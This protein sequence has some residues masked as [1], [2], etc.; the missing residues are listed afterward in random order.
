MPPRGKTRDQVAVWAGV[1]ARTVQDAATVQRHDPELFQRVKA[2]ELAAE[3][4]ARRVRRALR[5]QALQAP[6]LPEGP[7]ELIYADPPWQLGNPDGRHAPENHYPTMP[8]EQITALA[9]PA[10]EHAL[11]LLWAVNCLLP[12]ALQVVEAWG[13][14]YKTNL[15]WVKPSIGLG[16]C[17]QPARAAPAGDKGTLPAPAGLPRL[18]ARGATRPSL[19]EAGRRLRANR[20]GLAAR[21]QARTLRPHRP[22]RLDRLGKPS[23]RARLASAR[24]SSLARTGGWIFGRDRATSLT[25]AREAR[26]E[27]EEVEPLRANGK[28]LGAYMR[29]GP[30]RTP[31]PAPEALLEGFC[32]QLHRSGR[33]AGTEARY[34]RV[35]AGFLGQVEARAS[36]LSAGELDAYLSDW[37]A[38]FAARHGRAP[39]PASYRGQVNALR[40]FYHYLERLELLADAQGRPLLNP[41]RAIACPPAAQAEND[42]LR[43]DED[44]ALLTCPGSLQERFAVALLRHT[45]MRVSEAAAVTLAELDLAAGREALRVRRSKSAAGRRTVP[46]PP[47]LLPLLSEWLAEL[48]LLRLEAPQTPLLSTRTGAALKH[49]FV[50]RLVKR[51]AHRAGVRPVLCMCGSER[52]P[53][54]VG[55][56]RNQNGHNLSEISPHTLRRTY[57]SDLLNRGLRLE[58]VSKLLG[59]ATTTI[60]E[61]AY[62]Q[63]LDETTRRELLSALGQA[64]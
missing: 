56:P 11:L 52:P 30:R 55:C 14:R 29:G 17:P 50:W 54:R 37:Q 7:F 3:L 53:H 21:L 18:G 64:S 24:R 44:E 6:P 23:A 20:A 26:R 32:A 5:D 8:L 4:A 60:T 16:T 35:L 46:L 58:V 33:A 59:H 13:F 43:P 47:V 40:S 2:G 34:R 28:R 45:G 12:E 38:R 1:S 36:A 51:A 10:A 22:P 57:A 25:R 15:V 62:A 27:P 61:R 39:A 63:L 19:R 49:S 41:T 31:T 9:P 48:R 42:W